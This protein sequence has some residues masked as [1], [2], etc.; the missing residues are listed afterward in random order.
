MEIKDVSLKHHTNAKWGRGQFHSCGEGMIGVCIMHNIG[1]T[2]LL[3]VLVLTYMPMVV[4]DVATWFAS[5]FG[6]LIERP[7]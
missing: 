5:Q 3:A 6:L 7:I 1:R 4:C 2:A